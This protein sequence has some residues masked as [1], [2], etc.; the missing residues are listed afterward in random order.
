MFCQFLLQGETAIDAHEKAGYARDDGNAT[1]LAKN[2][3]V[4]ERVRELQT[5]VAKETKV[6]VE[7]ICRE[8]DEAN[9]V[10]KERG[11]ASAMVSA[12]A[13]RAKLAGL[14]VEKVE[15]GPAGAFGKCESVEEV[16]DEMLQYQLP[17]H[18]S[19]TAQDRQGLIDLLNEHATVVEEYIAAIK[20]RPINPEYIYKARR[21]E[22]AR[23]GNGKARP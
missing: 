6:T 14:M 18:A 11:Q 13:L 7:S 20:A 1:R 15:I 17:P 23:L 16:A 21:T 5:E 22:L 19:V 4:M 2:P 8:L 3:K 12:S 10:A 9:A